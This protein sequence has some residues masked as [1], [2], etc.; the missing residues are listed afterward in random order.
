MD[1]RAELKCCMKRILPI[2][3]V[4]VTLIVV[5]T[6][7]ATALSPTQ[8]LHSLCVPVKERIS[9]NWAGYAVATD[10]KT[11]QSNAV[12]DVKG[13]W[14]VPSVSASTSDTFSG[15]WIGID[16]YYSVTVEQ[17]GTEQDFIN[18]HPIYD[19]W[20]EIYPSLSQVINYPVSPGDTMTA[21]IK[22][23][24]KSQFQL[25][26]ND[27]SFDSAIH[28]DWNFSII[29]KT[30][31][32]LRQSAEWIVEAPWVVSGGLHPMADFGSVDFSDAQATIN[33]HTGTIKDSAWHKDALTM[34][35]VTSDGIT[36]AQPSVLSSDGSSFS[37]R[38]TET[39][40]QPI[41]VVSPNG[42]EKWVIGTI[43]TINWISD[44]IYGQV[45]ID[46]SQ[47]GGTTWK[48]IVNST[49]NDGNQ[50]WKVTGPATAEARIRVVSINNQDVYD[51]SD[52]NF[53][54]ASPTIT[55]VSPN[56]GGNWN[57]GTIQTITWISE[58]GT[59]LVRIDLSRDGGTTWKTI[60]SS[61]PNDGNQAWKVTGPATT[62][63]RIR[64]V[65]I[66]DVAVLDVSDANF[67]IAPP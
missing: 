8:V 45:R 42:G 60:V 56:G 49:P 44:G 67:T 65:S 7:A 33:G 41:T 43:Q 9:S 64:V 31:V 4:L 57:F 18:G 19:A 12:S 35:M 61:T 17:I 66:S 59:G 38:R 50:A 37:I 6:P 26:L 40:P 24:G 52:A 22:Y 28:S 15:V 58:G 27:K 1:A 63:A 47:D 13:Q 53:T 16:G 46:L 39:P 10:L 11:P 51:V 30:N 32:T 34:V 25:T 36:Q 2:L 55:I 48:T 54:I 23:I 5:A 21:E 62:D 14:V 29:K 3:G 20:F